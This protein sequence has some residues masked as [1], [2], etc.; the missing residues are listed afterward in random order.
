MK[1]I[2][3]GV[4]ESDAAYLIG[5]F[6][7]PRG[8]R[9]IGQVAR[10]K[11]FLPRGEPDRLTLNV[12]YDREQQ[13][14]ILLNDVA[15][16]SADVTGTKAT[17][18]FTF[19]VPG[20][21]AKSESVLEIRCSRPHPLD[22][23][24]PRCLELESIEIEKWDEAAE[25]AADES[26]A[27]ESAADE[28]TPDMPECNL[29]FGDIHVHS[30][31]SPCRPRISGTLEENYQWAR[32][33]GWD[34][35]AIADHDTFMSDAMWEQSIEACQKHNDPGSFATIFA[36]EWTSFFFGQM[37]AYSRSPDLALYRCTD[38]AYDSPPKL[39]AALRE[40]GVPA[41]TVYHHMAASG[42]ATTWD[43]D[44]PEMLPLIEVYSIWRS[45]ET[46]EGHVS[47]SRKKLAGCTA[48]DALAKGLRV[49]FIGGGDTHQHRPGER[50]IAGVY[51]P[52]CT[53]EAIWEALK[54]KRCYA[55]TGVKIELEFSVAGVGM[56]GQRTFTP[57]TQDTIF[58]ARVEARVKGTAPI[59]KIEV[60]ENGEVLYCQHENFGLREVELTFDVENLV[61]KYNASALS[62][63]SRHYYLRVTQEDGNMAW[64]SPVYLVRDWSGVE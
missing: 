11:L 34:F 14:E 4:P 38:Y 1:R 45:S 16:G 28:R 20:D 10:M 37:N 52:E 47:R 62:N 2:Q 33:D 8:R 17:E 7:G 41:F 5:G 18:Q 9:F 36:Y 19:D 59:R 44:D 29:Y 46:P 57:Y 21:L 58:P 12:W 53:R 15:I 51:A 31:F 63:P 6:S 48:R 60:I 24:Q 49:G 43:Y 27:D 39:W 13:I 40:A 30:N 22:A 26:A 64:S 32:E 55:T 54:A 50:G 35:V 25:S 61:R 3:F 23:H 56:G 42:W